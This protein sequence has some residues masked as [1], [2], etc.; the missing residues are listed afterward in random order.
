MSVLP[1]IYKFPVDGNPV[2][3]GLRLDLPKKQRTHSW[4]PLGADFKNK[5]QGGIVEV[6]VYACHVC[7][8][9]KR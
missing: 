3:C 2:S 5:G 8:K 7:G 1:E 9:D 6:D 4:V